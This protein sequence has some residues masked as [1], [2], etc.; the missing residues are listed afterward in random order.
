MVGDGEGPS[1]SFRFE[2][3]VVMWTWDTWFG[4]W[5][6]LQLLDNGHGATCLRGGEVSRRRDS[7]WEVLHVLGMGML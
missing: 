6:D 5:Y 3:G 2:A 1:L 7:S 4:F